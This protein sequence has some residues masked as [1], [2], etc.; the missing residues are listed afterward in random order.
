MSEDGDLVTTSHSVSLLLTTV[1]DVYIHM[2][3]TITII[4]ILLV[5][6]V[7]SYIRIYS[8]L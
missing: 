7:Y 4:Y 1:I 6:G 3:N 5:L 8:Q 2:V